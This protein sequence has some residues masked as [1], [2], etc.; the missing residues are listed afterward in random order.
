MR[1]GT[2]H[3][4]SINIE[5]TDLRLV[6]RG[7]DGTLNIKIRGWDLDKI[8]R[9][10]ESVKGKNLKV[11]NV[12]DTKG[13]DCSGSYEIKTLNKQGNVLDLALSNL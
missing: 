1:I 8:N 5:N 6:D 11:K 3:E 10:L 9:F 2:K 12:Y 13:I 7:T 4:Y